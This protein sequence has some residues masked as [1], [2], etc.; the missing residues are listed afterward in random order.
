MA[1]EQRFMFDGAAV[2]EAV[3]VTTSDGVTADGGTHLLDISAIDARVLPNELVAAQAEAE[4]LMADF[5]GSAD[6]R[7]QMFTLFNGGQSGQPSAEWEA[8]Y[9]QLMSAFKDGA[10]PVRVELRSTTELQGAK[11]AFSLNGSTGQATIYLNADWLAGDGGE[12]GGADRA[13]I[14]SVL[15]EELGHYL[16]ARLNGAG[17]TA[18]DEGEVFSRV[19]ISA[20]D[21]Q[22]AS[23]FST[24]DDRGELLIDGQT[25]EV[26]F[27]SYNFV[28]AYQIVGDI[29]SGSISNGV[30]TRLLDSSYQIT[31]TDVDE[32]YEYAI[33]KESNTHNFVYTSTGL[34]QV[35][36]SDAINS[37]YFSGNDVSAIGL[38]IGGATYYGWISRP[39]K[40]GGKVV[41]FYFWTDVSAAINSKAAFSDLSAAQSDGNQDGDSSTLD[42]RG[43]VL[44]VDKSYFDNTL[45]FVSRAGVANGTY[46]VIGSSSD[47]VDAALNSLIV[48]N[49]AP[50]PANDSLTVGEDSGTTTVTAANGLLKNDTDPNDTN[51]TV[52]SFSVNGISTTVDPSNGGSYT[53]ANVGSITIHKDGSYSFTPQANY[54]GTVPPVTYTVSD[55]HGGVASAVLSIAV[56]GVNDVPLASD[57]GVSTSENTPR[58]LT[59]NDFGAY[60]D[61]END[62]LSKIQITQLATNGALQ[63]W[64]GAAWTAVTLNQEVTVAQI[65]QGMLR[66][67]PDANESG[68][69]YATI[70]FKVSDGQ[71]YSTA[72]YTLTVEV[73]AGNQVPLAE[74]DSKVVVEAGSGVA[75]AAATGNVLTD[76]VADFDREGQTLSVAT[77][78]FNG[79]SKAV[80]GATSI[81]GQ[82]G[83]L[84]I[85]SN[86]SYS[87]VLDNSLAAVDAMN[88]GDT[89]TE[90]FS[91]AVTDGSGSA[92]TTL[93][94]TIQG[95][96]DVPLGADDF[97]SFIEGANAS[98]GNHG[99]VTGDVL[100]N[101]SDVDNA[102]ET[103]AVK[104]GDGTTPPGG[105]DI[106]LNASSPISSVTMAITA[107]SGSWTSIVPTSSEQ[108]VWLDAAYTIKAVD[109]TGTQLTVHRSGSGV[110][111]TL[112]FS[113]N[114][115]LYN[116]ENTN[117]YIKDPGNA[118]YAIVSIDIT[119]AT[120]SSSATLSTTADI[121][122]IHA[123]YTVAGTGIPAGTTV[124]S[125][126][127]VNKTITLSQAVNI[128]N[129]SLTFHDPNAVSIDSSTQEY[130]Q[131]T[132]GYL[133]LNKNG[134]YTYTLTTDLGA[135]QVINEAFTYHVVDPANA[136]A[137]S[138]TLYIRVTGV[139]APRV[140]NDVLVVAE[141]SGAHLTFNVAA[142]NA[143]DSL[144]A[145]DLAGTSVTLGDITS[146]QVHGDNTSYSAGSTATIANVGTLRINA[147]GSIQ[148]DP[149][150]DYLGP[151]PTVVYTRTGSDNQPY[152]GSLTI[153]ISAQDDASLLSPDST[154]VLENTAATG[155]VLGND[156]DTDST[157]AVASFSYTSNGV[158]VSYAAGSSAHEIRDGA[159]NL[160]GTIVI[161]AN[162]SYTF[163]PAAG[164]NGSVP[165]IGYTS[166]TGA[167]S[168]LDI[169]VTA[170]NDAPVIDLD[171][172]AT[173][174]GFQQD[175]RQGAAGVAIADVDA[176]IT[177]IDDTQ[178]ESA[179]VTLS[180]AQ[181][182]DLLTMGTLPAG[183]SVL[184]PVSSGGAVTI[185]LSGAA[186]LADYQAAIHGITFSSSG[187]STV[188]R[189][190]SV[191]VNDGEVDSNVA[192]TT[193]TVSPNDDVLSVAGSEVNEASPY[194]MFAVS[195]VEGQWISLVLGETGSGTGHAA[196][197]T[198]FLPNLQYFD[199]ASWVDYNGGLIQ[200]PDTTAN[201][202]KLLVRTAILQ[203]SV[204]ESTTAGYETLKLTAYTAAGT[205]AWAGAQIRD[206]GQGAV[207]LGNNAGSNNAL[208]ANNPGDVDLAGPDYPDHLD[209]DRPIVVDSIAVNE[210]SQWAMFTVS[211][212]D[213]QIVSL[214]L[215]DMTATAGDGA[216]ADGSE[217]YGPALQY[218]SG[219]AWVAYNGSAVAISGSTLLVRTQIHQDT[220][221]EGQHAFALGVTKLSSGT[222]VYGTA[223]IYDDGTGAKYA[224][225]DDNDGSVSISNG[226]AAGFDDDRS[227]TV[228]SPEV[229]EASDFVVFTVTGNT[230]Q[231]VTL[232]LQDESAGGTVNGKANIN[233]LQTLKV[234]DGLDWVD[235]NPDNLPTFDA[236]GKIFVRA[237]ISEEQDP[238]YEGA[239]SFK[240][241]VTLSGR[242]TPVSGTATI[243]DDGSG[244]IYTGLITAG[245][246]A[247]NASGPFD[248]D[249]PASSPTLD[250]VGKDDVSEGS[251]AVFDVT[252]SAAYDSAKTITLTLGNGSTQSNDYSAS[253]VVTYIDPDTGAQTAIVASGGTFSLP[254]GVAAFKVR[255]D[256]VAD[257][258]FEGTE[259]FALTAA[260]NGGPSAADTAAIKDDGS[261][262]VYDTDGTING[263]ITPDNDTPVTEPVV[264]T[265]PLPPPP[266]QAAPVYAEPLPV[267]LIEPFAPA[268]LVEPVTDLPVLTLAH[269]I[270]EQ[271][272][273][274]GI[275]SSFAIPKDAFSHT[276]PTEVL[277]LSAA[278]ADGQQ[279][280]SWI[281]FDAN[282]GT[283]RFEAPPGFVGELKLKVVARDSKG[284]EASTIFRFNV[285]KK[286]DVASPKGKLSFSEQLR[287]ANRDYGVS[288]GQ[289]HG[290]QVA[291]ADVRKVEGV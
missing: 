247:T 116:Y 260:V 17:D 152:T 106:T 43:F 89:K 206:D 86:G 267:L 264:S 129:T 52:I 287:S 149:V 185:T 103:L 197:G 256:T 145:N 46:K 237:G 242:S 224:F 209:D 114:V 223:S 168:T 42:N 105:T 203:D 188:Q 98:S 268:V 228:D 148:F 37:T 183:I 235:Y 239:E 271:Y 24:L 255:V 279:L 85:E 23:S 84:T 13:S 142:G 4:K 196:M 212:N 234:W 64:N 171:A 34:G 2:A 100:V 33:D 119:N 16:D 238:Q 88:S 77:V 76:G 250:V 200:I 113:D 11:G 3:A 14:T 26:E 7:Q 163:T 19:V 198:D 284:N 39:I 70:K 252:L 75:A 144:S 59:L 159:N 139:D 41:G 35:T 195:G 281:R 65:L 133:I 266:P 233:E 184:G 123:G 122:G 219:T 32:T 62:P 199:G 128:A 131:G 153:S 190:V 117:L 132:Y 222:A 181:A 115:A 220:L 92:T 135:S 187:S 66:F 150:D 124:V 22:T 143:G 51:L 273:D 49:S 245:A 96:N 244:T 286:R 265:A 269:Q 31:N 40:V 147:D 262:K 102:H 10:Y 83:T 229:N 156:T 6:A 291:L 172:S 177:D 277:Q 288:F 155:N 110:S 107:V 146:F 27:A 218:W 261:G 213:G 258:S 121:S 58:I 211:G 81:K 216:P 21:P 227:L 174:S 63:F 109:K 246:P 232:A 214:A 158:T 201:N 29:E 73:T 127:A 91:Y 118:N 274:S 137:G 189:V 25:I 272:A 236:N 231:T 270:P 202:G 192:F 82:Y 138:A 289:R 157:L 36:V 280:P 193:I 87:Y 78:I 240:L 15:I 126:D 165:Q 173:G 221:F 48:P 47:R 207:F 170:V 217:D 161:N 71:A 283:F 45:G 162:G 248:H 20:A 125:V 210:D 253:M 164:W 194:V 8:A 108:P 175:Y 72:A 160:L 285:G 18:G 276:D 97:A 151:V 290:Q 243:K 140:A 94:L 278:Q 226:P 186:S 12:I 251:P 130:F 50:T 61:P 53:I 30:D 101:D 57:D 204:W 182:G 120:T 241:N 67:A 95:T 134:S 282:S 275:K 257:G 74:A 79:Y 60:S 225:D 5:L 99:T 178:I 249:Q 166:N 176:A 259:T 169:V 9:A 180:N 136:G 112:V 56:S 104:L 208:A 141:D 263:A 90:T 254:A 191:Q 44:V 111:A 230:G 38:N 28:T 1:L 154:T 55:G 215:H 205:A 179:V 68:S 93:T 80:S 167:S 54:Y 69:T